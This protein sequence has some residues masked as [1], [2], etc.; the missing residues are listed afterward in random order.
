MSNAADLR[1]YLRTGDWI[2]LKSATAA[3]SVHAAHESIRVLAEQG[4]LRAPLEGLV[5]SPEDAEGLT[6][7]G[8]VLRY[9]AWRIRGG[10]LAEHTPNLTM[11]AYGDVLM[12][13]FE[14]LDAAL[15]L[16]P[17]DPLASGFRSSL[18]VEEDEE[19][20][21]AAIKRIQEAGGEVAAEALSDVLSAWTYKWGMSQPDMWEAFNRLYDP[22]RLSTL[23][24]APQAHWEQQTHYLWFEKKGGKAGRYY[25]SDSVRRALAAASDQ[26]LDAPPDTDPTLLRHIDGW[27]ARVFADA[28]NPSRAQAHFKRLGRHV[29]TA[30]WSNGWAFL[31]PEAR[32]RWARRRSGL[33]FG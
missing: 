8:G 3:M 5:S 13:A 4:G 25:R 21:R 1:P 18:S 17:R 11:Q 16:K 12:Q 2:G 27:M 28:G 33:W 6:L 22:S 30:I 10:H 9:R 20:K 29:S 19:G 15:A 24:L 32:M 26:A 7:A 31:S 23:A 14:L